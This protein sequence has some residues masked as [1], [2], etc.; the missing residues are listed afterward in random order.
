NRYRD[1]LLDALTRHDENDLITSA[2][3]EG[4]EIDL[5][6]VR[7]LVRELTLKRLIQP[8]LAGSGREHVGIQPLLDA[9]CDFLPSPL[10]RPA[11]TGI[12]PKKGN[13]EEK[14]KPD[15]DEPFC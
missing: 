13:K 7:R 15:L 6:A 9:A 11:V 8:V 3:L 10:D 12:N 2:L 14:R 4:R 1:E 5:A